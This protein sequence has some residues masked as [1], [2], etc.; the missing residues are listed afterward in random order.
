M[1]EKE[2][3]TISQTMNKFLILSKMFSFFIYQFLKA[4]DFFV[5][6]I[7]LCFIQNGYFFFAKQLK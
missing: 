7:L 2:E 4:S 6:F 1:A 3:R 5:F